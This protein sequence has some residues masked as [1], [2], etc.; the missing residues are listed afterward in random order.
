MEDCSVVQHVLYV[1]SQAS[2][3]AINFAK[4][5]VAFSTNVAMHLQVQLASFLGMQCVKRHERYLGLRTFVGKNKKQTFSFIKEKVTQRLHG[6]K[7]KLLS[8]ADK[9]LLI[10]VVTQALPAYAMQNFLLPK[11]F[12]EEL[13]YLMAPFWW[14][15]DVETQKIHWMSWEKMCRPKS[16]KGSDFRDLYAFN[17]VLLAKQG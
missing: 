15:S 1:Y 7:G 14:S 5:S 3:Q 9:V 13:Q 10:K 6:W 8:S 17:L 4:S 16:E 2:S 12:C 11:T